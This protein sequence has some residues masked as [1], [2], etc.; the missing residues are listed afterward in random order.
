MRQRYFLEQKPLPDAVEII[1]DGQEAQ[2]LIKVMRAKPAEIVEL[3]DGSGVEWQA[4]I[5]DIRRNEAT[6]EILSSARVSREATVKLT[7]GIALP[8]GDRQKWVIGKLVELGVHQVVPLLTE[9][10]V[11][12]PVE[13]AIG[14]L[15]RQVV[16]ASKQCGRNCLMEIAEPCMFSA[17]LT[18]QFTHSWIAH[19]LSGEKPVNVPFAGV[20]GLRVDLGTAGVIIGPEGGFSTMEMSAAVAAGWTPV[21]LGARILRIETA[22]LAVAAQLLLGQ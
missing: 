16:E 3:F 15:R 18:H 5:V 20:D 4:R 21:E 6:L 17:F 8:K 1:L 9:N 2:H 12:Q 7:L 19:P 14:R 11:A 13:K 10:G 22:A